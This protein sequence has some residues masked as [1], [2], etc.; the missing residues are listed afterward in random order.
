MTHLVQNLPKTDLLKHTETDLHLLSLSEPL[1]AR[2]LSLFMVY[3][4][5][6]I[7]AQKG[8][9]LSCEPYGHF[10]KPDSKI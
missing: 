2:G 5:E 4:A 1:T 3:K 9:F 8:T 10:S 7:G 6:Y